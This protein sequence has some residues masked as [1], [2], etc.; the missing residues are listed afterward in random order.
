[1]RVFVAL[2]I[3]KATIEKISELQVPLEGVRWQKV[4][5]MHLTLRFIGEADDE[6]IEELKAGFS[7]IDA[8]PFKLEFTGLG[9]F[10]RRGKPK[11]LWVGVEKSEELMQLKNK[12]DPVCDQANLD[13]EDR[14]YKP[15]ITLGKNKYGNKED[16]L[17][18]LDRYGE[19]EFEP[20]EVNYFTLYSS[21]LTPDGA[22]HDPLE[23]YKLT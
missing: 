9:H 17:R 3:P 15:H 5:Q 23:E 4:S 6:L 16:I 21:T 20:V 1:M 13:P 19:I 11:V 7:N 12:I 10:P 18:Y 2:P 8:P 22:I 14:E